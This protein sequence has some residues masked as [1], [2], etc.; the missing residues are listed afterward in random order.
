MIIR[1]KRCPMIGRVCMDQLSV[2]VTDCP[3]VT[4]G[5]VVTFIGSDGGETITLGE[6]AQFCG[7]IEHE[8]LCMIGKRVKRVYKKG[9]V[10]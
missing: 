1:G 3:G 5:D 4:V 8:V 9:V 7:T 6:A 10:K 2:D